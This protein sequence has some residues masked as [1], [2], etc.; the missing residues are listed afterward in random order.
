MGN[1]E[2]IEY[3]GMGEISKL[4]G[5]IEETK[6]KRIF[7]VTGKS[8][9]D[10]SGAREHIEIAL[11]NLEVLHFQDFATLPLYEDVL[12][13]IK[14]YKLF[15]PDLV[16]AVGGGL[17]IDIAKAVNILALQPER[18]SLYIEG[19]N[20]I[21]VPG[22]NFVAIPTT[23]GS[24]S[25]ATSFAVVYK[26]KLKYSLS[27]P[28]I[29]P[30]YSLVDP[31]LS[32]SVSKEGAISSALDA[33]AQSIESYW[34]KGSTD[35]SKSYSL[36]A[37]KKILDNIYLAIERRDR[38][39]MIEISF[40]AHLAGK[41]INIARTTACHAL[42]YGLTYKFSVPHGLAVAILLP[43][44]MR[45]NNIELPYGV[46]F[47]TVEDILRRFGIMGLS[48]YG[49]KETDIYSLTKEVNL[50]RLSNNP[51]PISE[52]DIQSFYKAVL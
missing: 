20:H 9:Y 47:K 7:L 36:E 39:A 43:G 28:L 49:V 14:L 12:R 1:F 52:S 6:A 48:A 10:S 45:F 2:Q 35:K 50:E 18:E 42:S 8:S 13:G 23:S 15:N 27:S 17:T 44:I 25:E 30:T 11:K 41:A 24:G 4:A 19:T 3:I 33:L 5:I 32:F 51:R 38:E 34:S 21:V 40:A 22:K 26:D 46:T 16:V 31:E 37:L 29:L